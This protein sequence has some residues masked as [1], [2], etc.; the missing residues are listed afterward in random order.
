MAGNQTNSS[1]FE[2]KYFIHMVR[3]HIFW[4]V[5]IEDLGLTIASSSFAIARVVQDLVPLHM[6]FTETWIH[7]VLFWALSII[8]HGSTLF[9]CGHD[10][11]RFYMEPFFILCDHDS[12][13]SYTHVGYSCIFM[14]IIC[15]WTCM[16]QR[17]VL[18][19]IYLSFR[20]LCLSI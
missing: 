20:Y 6:T 1:L 8:E 14:V 10:S 3:I 9:I 5:W 11:F 7:L 17:S 13:I 16:S 18:S 19:N 4:A 12:Y 15:T 2:F